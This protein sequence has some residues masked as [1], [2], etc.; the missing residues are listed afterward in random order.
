M[1]I[2]K[3]SKAIFLHPVCA[4]CG[5]TMYGHVASCCTNKKALFLFWISIKGVYVFSVIR[6]G[7][8]RSK[9][10]GKLDFSSSNPH[11]FNTCCTHWMVGLLF[12]YTCMIFGLF[13]SNAL[14]TTLMAL[15]DNSAQNYIGNYIFL[16]G[17]EG[18]FLFLFGS[19]CIYHRQ[20]TIAT[21]DDLLWKWKWCITEYAGLSFRVDE[22][23]M[24][25]A[26]PTFSTQ[27][28]F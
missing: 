10:N 12:E 3:H 16:N 22:L 17:K 15:R 2:C 4:L 26:R 28:P 1:D 25:H 19:T 20:Y 13:L 18:P 11:T 27:Y 9:V 21:T 7:K 5:D 6:T 8:W 23:S 24:M 14:L